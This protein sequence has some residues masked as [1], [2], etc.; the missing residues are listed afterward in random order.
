MDTPPDPLTATAEEIK[1]YLQLLVP[2]LTDATNIQGQVDAA[3]RLDF[4]IDALRCKRSDYDAL[5]RVLLDSNIVDILFHLLDDFTR[6][7]LQY[8]ALNCLV[9]ILDKSYYYP[10]P[11]MTD[12]RF[13]PS[14]MHILGLTSNHGLQQFAISEIAQ[15]TDR[16][17]TR[18]LL[19]QYGNMDDFVLLLMHPGS[20]DAQL[21]CMSRGFSYLTHNSITIIL[22]R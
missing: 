3:E 10:E 19:L 12:P 6:T 13:V 20:S 8:H 16:S 11:L 14:L 17:S 5:R 2:S 21:H 22:C 7:S 9:Y 18:E 4:Y 15:L 1:Q